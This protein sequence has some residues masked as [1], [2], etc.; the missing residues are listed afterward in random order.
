MMAKGL[1]KQRE[2]LRARLACRK[3]ARE[4]ALVPVKATSGDFLSTV[5]SEALP[6]SCA[7]AAQ[8]PPRRIIPSLA[9]AEDAGGNRRG[10]PGGSVEG[11]N[12]GIRQWIS[13]RRWG[14]WQGF[15]CKTNRNVIS[16]GAY[17]K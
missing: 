4:L 2:D 9:S 17:I 1:A 3:H 11:G 7:R 5:L 14:W 15:L 12:G 8:T 6:H 10:V 13:G 16:S